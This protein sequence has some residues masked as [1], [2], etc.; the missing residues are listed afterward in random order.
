MKFEKNIN[1]TLYTVEYQDS[2]EAKPRTT[3]SDSVVL[4]GGKLAALDR[5]GLRPAGYI[6]QEYEHEGY[7]I[8]GIY[9]GETLGATVDL[10]QLWQKTQYQA[11][12]ERLKQQIKKLTA[13]DPAGAA[14]S[15][16]EGVKA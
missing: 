9:K 14:S 6:A 12:H 11:E 3:Y 5:L 4:D 7:I 8:V 16:A 2:R 15:K 1:L 10:A 13:Q